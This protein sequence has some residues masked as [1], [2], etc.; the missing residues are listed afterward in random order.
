MKY[1]TLE[2]KE[3]EINKE[4]SKEKN[5]LK[6]IDG[7]KPIIKDKENKNEKKNEK[8]ILEELDKMQYNFDNLMSIGVHGTKVYINNKK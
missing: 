4:I 1:E 6:K 8:N 5:E 2:D 3:K 7:G